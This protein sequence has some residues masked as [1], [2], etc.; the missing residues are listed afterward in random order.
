MGYVVLFLPI[1]LSNSPYSRYKFVFSF[2]ITLILTVVLL[3]Y[4]HIGNPFRILPAILITCYAFAPAIL[5]AVICTF[6]L[7]AFLKSG[8]CIAFS[9]V[10]YYFTEYVVDILFGT[11]E[12]SYQVN[13]SD[14]RLCLEGNIYS[15]NLVSLLLVSAVLIGIGIV[16][17]RKK[18]K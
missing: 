3:L 1:L 8:I 15:L 11:N 10:V 18:S 4:I 14:W 5:C 16:R 9:T 17:I 6:P 2:T 7:D 13:F 12:R